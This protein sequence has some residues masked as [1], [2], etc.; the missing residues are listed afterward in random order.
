M[1]AVKKYEVKEK[2][3]IKVYMGK[4]DKKE[5]YGQ[6][7]E[8]FADRNYRKQLP[9]LINDVDKIWYLVYDK[10]KFIGFFG[11][12][13]CTENTLISDIYFEDAPNKINAFKYTAEFLVDLYQEEELKVLT[14]I[15]EEQN[16]WLKLGFVKA[17]TRG[18]YLILI[19]E[20]KK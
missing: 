7:G 20:G 15:K 1:N 8:F 14:K 4:Y 10:N 18:N 17:G 9:Y 3:N 5:F 11:V 13:I 19:K 12:K 2:Y 16:I 6:M